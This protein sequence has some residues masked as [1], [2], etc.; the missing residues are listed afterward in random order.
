[1]QVRCISVGKRRKMEE[2][3]RSIVTFEYWVIS[4]F[5]WGNKGR[6]ESLFPTT[7]SA[8]ASLSYIWKKEGMFPKMLSAKSRFRSACTTWRSCFLVRG[9]N[10][11]LC[12]FNSEALTLFEASFLWL[13]EP[14]FS[15]YNYDWQSPLFFLGKCTSIDKGRWRNLWNASP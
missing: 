3:S 10:L 15:W 1:M 5:L 11:A 7:K 4:L 6:R 13:P 9:Q 8:N 12:H 2:R 14:S